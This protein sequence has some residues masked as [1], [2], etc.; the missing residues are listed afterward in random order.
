MILSKLKYIFFLFSIDLVYFIL[1]AADYLC[2]VV[3][4]DKMILMTLFISWLDMAS[5][6]QNQIIM[7]TSS[8]HHIWADD[9]GSD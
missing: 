8:A 7:R 3:S 1:E 9:E 5:A 6:T 2:Y 4:D